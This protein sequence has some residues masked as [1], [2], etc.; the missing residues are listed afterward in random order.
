MEAVVDGVAGFMEPAVNT[1]DL[2][3]MDWTRVM[4]FV[5]AERRSPSPMPQ[6]VRRRRLPAQDMGFKPDMAEIEARVPPPFGELTDVLPE[7]GARRF[8][9][10][11]VRDHRDTLVREQVLLE[12]VKHLQRLINNVTEHSSCDICL[13]PLW[14]AQVLACGHSFCGNCYQDLRQRGI[15]ECGMCRQTLQG[16]AT[17]WKMHHLCTALYGEEPE[18]VLDTVPDDD[19]D[20]FM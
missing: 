13:E 6:T 8:L 16:P 5:P 14:S 10:A 17:D 19:L 18:T 11:M 12:E 9:R 2:L 4:E 1:R 7:D 3:N 20:V 15:K